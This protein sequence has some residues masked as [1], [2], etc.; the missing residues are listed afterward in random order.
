MILR[1]GY[2]TG[3]SIYSSLRFWV[4]VVVLFEGEGEAALV[5]VIVSVGDGDAMPLLVNI[6]ICEGIQVYVP[7]GDNVGDILPV[8]VPVSEQVIVGVQLPLSLEIF[9]AVGYSGLD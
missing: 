5:W 6:P 1:S 7:D 4:G 2:C 9:V 3:S 8:S